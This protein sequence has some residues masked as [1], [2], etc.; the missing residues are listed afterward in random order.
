MMK[1]E[2]VAERNSITSVISKRLGRAR[3][4]FAV[5]LLAVVAAAC[6]E[7]LTSTEYGDGAP[8]RLV[9]VPEDVI[10][11]P[12]DSVEFI[13][14]AF[15]QSGDTADVDVVWSATGGTITPSNARGGQAGTNGGQGKRSGWYRNGKC[16]T[17]QV[18]ATTVQGGVSA[19]ASVRVTCTEPGPVA[20]VTVTPETATLQ[21]GESIQLTAVAKDANG[22]TLTGTATWAPN[23]PS[24][25]SVD[26]N[27]LVRGEG[28]G[29]GTI[30]ATIDGVSGSASISVIV[31]SG[32]GGGGGGVNTAANFKVAFIGDQG[33]GSAALAVLRLIR[34]E[35]TD[36][37]LHQGDF[38]YGDNPTQ[39]DNN[40]TSVLGADF[41]YFAS[42]GN[43]D[44]NSFYGTGGYQE[45]LQQRLDRVSGATCTGD[46]GVNSA[47]EYQGLFFILSGAGTL[48]SGHEA[49]IR[50]QLSANNSTWRVCS[51]HKNQNAMQVGGKGNEVGWGPYE[52]C[53]EYG[54]IVA[55]GHEHSYSRTKTLI[56]TQSQT[57]DPNWPDPAILRVAPGATFVFVSGLGGASIRDQERCLPSTYPYGCNGEWASI[58]T[59]N[60]GAQYGALFIE[61]NVD[62][63]PNKAHGYFKDIDG[64]VVDDFTVTSQN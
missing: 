3:L 44:D 38:D 57:V 59:S 46:L 61:F 7:L 40:I 29:S 48:G 50:E 18:T 53:R 63:D 56:S 10:I 17:Y 13:A 27:G 2:A 24:V 31:P 5:I 21:V 54:A 49:Y 28:E 19:S 1:T 30:T 45:K 35:G 58:Y 41:P 42:V 26:Q 60:Q 34:D 32:G 6:Q 9:I 47:C 55:T 22:I 52:A 23:D 15:T 43:H 25:A 11:V 36:M 20:T 16:G 51:W 14:V 4:A 62:G 12:S 64:R 37:V 8:S 33:D 39:W